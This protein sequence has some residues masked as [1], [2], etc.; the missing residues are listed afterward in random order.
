ML[1]KVSKVHKGVTPI[2]ICMLLYGIFSI[3]SRDYNTS[4][5]TGVTPTKLKYCHNSKAVYIKLFIFICIQD[6]TVFKHVKSLVQPTLHKISF[7][8]KSIN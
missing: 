2:D 6:I 5:N 8:N 1:C 7:L 3:I 4:P